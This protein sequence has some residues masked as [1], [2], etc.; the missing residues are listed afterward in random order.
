MYPRLLEIPLPFEVFGIGTIT[1]HS[2]GAMMALAFLVAAWVTRRELDRLYAA[3]RL[4]AVRIP[5]PSRKGKG[6][7][8]GRAG[9]RLAYAEVSPGYIMGTVVVLAVVGGLGGAKLFY[10]LDHL[11]EFGR[12]PFGMI[13]SRGGLTFYGGLVV[14]TLLIAWYVRRKGVPLPIFADTILPT[15]LLAYGIGRIGCHLAGD[16]DWGIVANAAAQPGWVP[17][18]LWAETYPNNIMGVVLPEPGVYP[19]PLYE[20]GM[21]LI[22]FAV[23]WSLR[24][25]PFRSGWL[26]WLT[27][28]FIGIERFLIEKIRVNNEYEIL[29]MSVTQAEVISVVL[30]AVAAAGL[31]LTTRRRIPRAP[32]L[33]EAA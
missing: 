19:T 5:A 13:F 2:F 28:L 27:L 22:L 16:G 3:G 8:A 15:V 20:L 31:A 24:K 11:E 25:H 26:F 21:A 23:L 17:D 14:A 33:P 4:K 6:N 32:V 10:L 18:W 7:A 12:D 9:S 30:M 29:G 1:F